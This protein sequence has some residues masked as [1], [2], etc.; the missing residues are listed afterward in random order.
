MCECRR[1][2]GRVIPYVTR[3]PSTTARSMHHANLGGNVIVSFSDPLGVKCLVEA[4]IVETV[5]SA[6]M[7]P[8]PR[9]GSSALRARP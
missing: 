1:E 9:V 7:V 8:F 3:Y 2:F 4:P 5:A 6:D